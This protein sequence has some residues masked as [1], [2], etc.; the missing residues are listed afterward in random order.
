MENVKL[1]CTSCRN[2]CTL[3]VKVENGKVISVKGNGCRRGVVSAERKLS[4][5]K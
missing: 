5:G 4:E 3:E 2:E 1:K